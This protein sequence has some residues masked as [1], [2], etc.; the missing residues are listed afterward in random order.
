MYI[1]HSGWKIGYYKVIFLKLFTFLFIK[2]SKVTL[3]LKVKQRS[4]IYT[5]KLVNM[6][7]FKHK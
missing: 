5:F 2:N 7:N 6:D 1:L 3:F 4:Q